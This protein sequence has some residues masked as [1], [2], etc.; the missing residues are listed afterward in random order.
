MIKHTPRLTSTNP[1]LEHRVRTT[2][3]GQADWATD[4]TN[5]C[6]DCLFWGLPGG[7]YLRELGPRPCAKYAALMN[8]RRGK[9]VPHDA[10]ACRF[11]TK[12]DADA[13]GPP[14]TVSANP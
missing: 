13:S 5:K 10:S 12:F 4:P 9:P 7:R 14:P 6:R 2:H 11:F 3:N 1:E 8:G